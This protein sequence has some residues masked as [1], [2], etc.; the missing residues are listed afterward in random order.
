MININGKNYKLV[1]M[2]TNILSEFGKNTKGF[3]KN[4]LLKFA[5]GNH[6]LTTSVYNIVELNETQD[7]F[8]TKLKSSL[9]ILPLGILTSIEEIIQSEKDKSDLD[10]ELIAF[11]VGSP[12]MFNVSLEHLFKFTQADSTQGSLQKYHS[13]LEKE[14]LIWKKARLVPNEHWQK[15]CHIN[16]NKT[17]KLIGGDSIGEFSQ[18]QLDNCR[19][20]QIRSYIANMFIYSCKQKLRLASVIDAYNTSFLPYVEVYLTERTVGSWLEEAK[21]KFPYLKTKTIYKVSDF[22]DK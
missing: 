22:Y 12:H 9:G 3:S 14:L 1:Y 2:D 19:S 15:N 6:M 21:N 13:K 8:K 17:M 20:L 11:A 18:T 7:D 5:D 16:I 10:N 4:F